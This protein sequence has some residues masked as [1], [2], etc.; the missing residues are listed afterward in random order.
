MNSSM[1]YL[2]FQRKFTEKMVH[3]WDLTLEYS[4]DDSLYSEELYLYEFIKTYTDDELIEIISVKFTFRT[5][6]YSSDDWVE[7]VEYDTVD[8]ETFYDFLNNRLSEYVEISNNMRNFIDKLLD[9]YP[10][11]KS[12]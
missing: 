1:S 7:Q 11:I 8:L 3:T 5:R 4:S 6:D 12:M 9:E 2:N 10:Y